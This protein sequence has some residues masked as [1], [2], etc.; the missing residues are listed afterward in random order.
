MKDEPFITT[1]AIAFLVVLIL[2]PVGLVWDIWGYCPD[3]IWKLDLTALVIWILGTIGYYIW[4]KPSQ[5]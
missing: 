4:E 5:W 3:W 1:A 2:T